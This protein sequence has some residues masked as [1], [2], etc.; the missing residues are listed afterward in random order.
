MS[1]VVDNITIYP[2]IVFSGSYYKDINPDL[3]HIINASYIPDI[4]FKHIKPHPDKN[5]NDEL[6]PINKYLINVNEYD[7][8]NIWVCVDSLIDTA[9][10]HEESENWLASSYICKKDY[11]LWALDIPARIY[12]LKTV[13]DIGFLLYEDLVPNYDDN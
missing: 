12:K 4:L 6:I 1:S 13:N 2:G 9:L 5:E 7:T 3:F 8:I 11:D 10:G